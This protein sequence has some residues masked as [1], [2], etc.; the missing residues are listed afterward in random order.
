MAIIQNKPNMNY[1][2]WGSNGNIAVPTSEK[3]DL[4]WIIEKP[5]NEMMNWV[6]NRQ[7][8][9]LQFINPNFYAPISKNDLYVF[10]II[11]M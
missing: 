8:S 1:G 9:M 5:P 10:S 4:G 6:Q 11:F 3:V 7:D 2:V